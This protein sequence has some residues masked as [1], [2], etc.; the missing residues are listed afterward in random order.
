MLIDILIIIF[1]IASLF[2]GKEIGFIRQLFST[3]GFFSGLYIG[4]LLVPYTLHFAHSTINRSIITII[5]T[6]GSAL[7]VMSISE[8]VGTAIKHKVVVKK[9]N[10][11]DNVFGS[12]L[13]L[14][15]LLISIWLTAAILI[16]LPIPPLQ[17]EIRS[18][19]IIAKLDQL[20]PPSPQ[21][22]I[23]D[24]S[25]LIE[26]N[27][28]PQ[29]FIGNEPSPNSNIP[30]PSSLGSLNSAVL[31]DKSSVVKIEGQGCGGIVEGSG[32]VVGKNLIATNAHVIA[33]IK[34]PYVYYN[35][36]A[37]HATPIWFDPN[38]DFAVL[39]VSGIQAA[40][41]LTI[42]NTLSINGTKAAVLG[43]PGG[44]PFTAGP[45][46]IIDNFIA[47]GRN[48]YGNGHTNRSVY[49]LKA[50]VIP[51]NSGGP[52]INQQAQVVGIVFAESTTYN[53]VGY[54]LT[55]PQVIT[56]LHQAEAR[57]QVT[58]TG[59]CAE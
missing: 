57:D 39:S 2:R 56:E 55:T 10:I 44:G 20:F 59:Q 1:A 27:G 52:L 53:H 40:H 26:P 22:I 30:L 36:S 7:I 8:I 29:V 41:I 23:A 3:V 28:F 5:T 6:L 34:N 16:A 13:S 9:F 25:H 42:Q 35:G 31:A 37:H 21:T 50:N 32:F 33:G 43:Y 24:L 49:E 51:G 17:N 48:I 18:S 38:L 58:T 15:S 45:A 47:T 19:K 54:A 14:A 46:A 12:I 11:V 4:T